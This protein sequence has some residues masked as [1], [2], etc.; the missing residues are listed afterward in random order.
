MYRKP[1]KSGGCY[2]IAL[3]PAKVKFSALS[4]QNQY[5]MGEPLIPRQKKVPYTLPAIVVNV[6][7]EW[8]VIE[9]NA[10][11]YSAQHSTKCHRT[12]SLNAWAFKEWD[13]IVETDLRTGLFDTQISWQGS[14]RDAEGVFY[15]KLSPKTYGTA[16]RV[17]TAQAGNNMTP[18]GS[19]KTPNLLSQGVDDDKSAV[20][21]I[22]VSD[23]AQSV[24][25]EDSAG[26]LWS[27][28]SRL[29]FR[30]PFAKTPSFCPH[31][32]CEM[33]LRANPGSTYLTDIVFLSDVSFVD[34]PLAFLHS[35][36]NYVSAHT[37]SGDAFKAVLANLDRRANYQVPPAAVFYC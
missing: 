16:L 6:H 21:Y 19:L 11:L 10:Q 30:S 24:L 33:Y 18:T 32:A 23:S 14:Y 5:E 36:S 20:S 35:L 1:A 22:T 9:G 3:S 34:T 17:R 25:C 13:K 4:L 12:N 27:T 31:L 28:S 2:N 26:Y 15:A 7:D 37:N 8:V 29:Y